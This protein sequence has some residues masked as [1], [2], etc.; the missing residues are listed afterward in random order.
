MH[1]YVFVPVYKLPVRINLFKG[2]M[3]L[4]TTVGG[5][6]PSFTWVDLLHHTPNKSGGGKRM[7]HVEWCQHFILSPRWHGDVRRKTTSPYAPGVWQRRDTALG[8]F[9]VKACHG[10]WGEGADRRGQS[11]SDWGEYTKSSWTPNHISVS[12]TSSNQTDY[13]VHVL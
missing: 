11:R 6:M 9:Q 12:R 3:F 13:D 4:P 8:D 7:L 2:R 1:S 10:H 5:D